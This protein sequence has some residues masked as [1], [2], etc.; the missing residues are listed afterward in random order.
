MKG[1]RGTKEPLDEEHGYD[2]TPR[3]TAHEIYVCNKLLLKQQLHE[4]VVPRHFPPS[5]QHL[6]LLV[7]ETPQP[8]LHFINFVFG[9][10]RVSEMTNNT[11]LHILA[12]NVTSSCR[13]S[14]SL[15]FA[16]KSGNS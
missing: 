11:R 5:S 4:P 8:L 1:G 10:A 16:S 3:P 14:K 12:P 7:S 6:G 15:I 9:L 2:Q 13:F